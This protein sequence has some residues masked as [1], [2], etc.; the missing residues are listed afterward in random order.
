MTFRI[1]PMAQTRKDVRL[2]AAAE[3]KYERENQGPPVNDLDFF[4]GLS[5]YEPGGRT[6][7]S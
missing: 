6:M 5:K 4:H 1:D 7:A 2:I 3:A